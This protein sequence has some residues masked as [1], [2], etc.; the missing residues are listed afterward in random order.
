MQR[1]VQQLVHNKIV[2]KNFYINA[3]TQTFLNL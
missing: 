2:V 3:F 1:W